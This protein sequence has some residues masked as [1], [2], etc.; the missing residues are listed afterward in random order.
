MES[1]VIDSRAEFRRFVE[2]TQTSASAQIGLEDLVTG[3]LAYLRVC[4]P[5]CT[6]QDRHGG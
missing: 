4:H 2:R 6:K 5:F 1:E 3:S